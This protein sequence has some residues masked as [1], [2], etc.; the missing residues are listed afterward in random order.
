[1]LTHFLQFATIIR[2]LIEMYSDGLKIGWVLK[3]EFIRS[4]YHYISMSN[5]IHY[6][7]LIRDLLIFR[8]EILFC[9]KNILIKNSSKYRCC[10]SMFNN[11]FSVLSCDNLLH[12]Y[13]SWIKSI[14]IHKKPFRPRSFD[15]SINVMYQRKHTSHSIPIRFLVPIRS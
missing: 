8:H 1:M 10:F 15:V 7:F 11:Y 13:W 6:E 5:F 14:F 12:F 9:I 2:P 4:V 3:M